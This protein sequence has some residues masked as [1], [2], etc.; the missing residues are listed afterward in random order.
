[1]CQESVKI[2]FERRCR[3]GKAGYSQHSKPPF[4]VSVSAPSVALSARCSKKPFF[5]LPFRCSHTKWKH[6]LHDKEEAGA[7]PVEPQFFTS[8]HPSMQPHGKTPPGFA[9]NFQE[10]IHSKP[11]KSS[12]GMS[13]PLGAHFFAPITPAK[14][15]FI[16]VRNKSSVSSGFVRYGYVLWV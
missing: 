12:N 16:P 11:P 13:P 4:S 1:M 6:G 15:V 5:P 2:H 10:A 14:I 8:A 9:S 3:R 7:G